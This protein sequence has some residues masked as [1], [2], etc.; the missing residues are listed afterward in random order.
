MAVIGNIRK[1][2]GLLI[3]V[4]GI[5]LAAFVLGDLS[6]AQG[7]RT[8]TVGEINGEEVGYKEFN[9]RVEQ[10]I[11]FR[12]QQQAK[13]NLTAAEA[14]FVRE[15]T[16]NQLVSEILLNEELD[17]LGLDI[18]IDELAELLHGSNPHYLVRQNFTDPTTGIFNPE[19]IINYLRTLNQQN[20]AAREQYYNFEQAIIKD[21]I[22][23]KF[24]TLISKGYYFP[25]NLAEQL[26]NNS[27]VTADIQFL[28]KD[29]SS[30]DDSLINIT[31][32]D[33]KDYYNKHI[34]EY[35]LK[36]ETR[37]VNYVVFEVTPSV[38]DRVETTNLVN[39]LYQEFITADNPISFVN[40]VSDHRYDSTFYKESQ[41]P[42]QIA[43][44]AENGKV[45]LFVEP[46]LD[47][48][49][50]YMAK[51][52][53]MQFRPDSMLA[54]HVLISYQGAQGAN[55]LRTKIKASQLADSLLKV[56]DHNPKK[57]A[58]IAR[59]YSDDP[60][61]KQNDGNI[62]WFA[63]MGMIPA[64]NNA[65]LNAAVGEVVMVETDFGFHIIEVN[66]K[67]NISRKYRVAIIDRA[68]EASSDTYQ[69]YWTMASKFAAENTDIISFTENIKEL[70]LNSRVFTGMNRMTSNIYDLQYPRQIVRWSFNENSELGSISPIFDF[71]GKYVIA[72]LI[73]IEESGSRAFEK[74]KFE[75]ESKVRAE[76]KLEYI[77]N[78][79]KGLNDFNQIAQKWGVT[80]ENVDVN[81]NLAVI[82][83]RGREPKVVGEIFGMK[84]GETETIV[85]S[86]AVFVVKFNELK[87]PETTANIDLFRTQQVSSF[88][89]RIYQNAVITALT[90]AADIE[91]SRHMFY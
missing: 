14:F 56:I 25:E 72:I 33:H 26:M 18:S 37:A 81:F 13:Q 90:N 71:D 40:S 29:A 70:G 22:N 3:I 60:S 75:V 79:L 55:I 62:G 23:T 36:E 28:A 21:Q 7:G 74:V 87:T 85:G 12:K 4:I 10:N 91:D 35:Q 57:L 67:K 32:S 64:F 34:E 78:E 45:G 27:T 84:K 68:I 76:K 39:E 69:D 38:N 49:V 51:L 89:N 86:K 66:G 77:Q 65:V 24:S 58:E 54:S 73:D 59:K 20:Q 2:S 17:A 80:S 53:D 82:G 61:A 16:W 8:N 42:I 6:K 31:E 43:Q 46:Y 52:V 44:K 19:I 41:L 63:D 1:H 48:E 47:N 88:T 83:S 5:A 15:Q 11:Q 9:S 30:V 50:F